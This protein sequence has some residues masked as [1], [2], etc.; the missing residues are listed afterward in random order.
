MASTG[1]G[2]PAPA[3]LDAKLEPGA[4]AGEYIVES[5]LGE[6]AFGTV[7]RAA[8]GVIGKPAAVKVLSL[9]HAVDPG[10]VARFIE[11]AR[12]VNRIGHPDIIDIFGFGKLP[13][14]RQFYVMELLHGETLADVLRKRAPM[15]PGEVCDLLQPVSAALDAAH[16]AGVAHRDVKPE[17]IFLHDEGGVLRPKLLDFGVAK[18]SGDEL[19][20]HATESGATVGTPSYMSP[21]QCVGKGVDHRADIYAFGV[22]AFEML[23]GRLPFEEESRFHLM[24]AHLSADVPDPQSL[25]PTLPTGVHAALQRIMAK[26]PE[27]RPAT[28]HDAWALLQ[29]ALCPGKA[30]AKEG[31]K[32]T[33]L[34]PHASSSSSRSWMAALAAVLVLGMGGAFLW[35]QL[36]GAAPLPRDVPPTDAV[37][38]VKGP[39]SSVVKSPP[40]LVTIELQGVPDEAVVQDAA[41]RV[42]RRGPGPVSVVASR[43]VTWS[44]KHNGAAH[45]VV[46]D[47]TS[48]Q[49]VV[50]PAD[51]FASAAPLVQPTM[52]TPKKTAAETKAPEKKASEKKAAAP[53]PSVKATKSDPTSRK[54]PPSGKKPPA[55]PPKTRGLNDLEPW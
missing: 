10:I 5:L 35:Q 17:N 6:G 23:T 4:E 42:L 14:G 2:R 31:T 28:V 52:T 9:R 51:A 3:V 46:V 27:D 53:S 40:T 8:H 50:V 45:D 13:D 18:L 32:A 38:G 54:A 30:V 12:A 24:A 49:T 55:S 21:E 11:E 33:V 25:V 29:S 1:S 48:A 37:D 43:Q 39:A 15:P 7:Y 22:L 19:G 44:V 36:S 47:A 16:G 41:G 20:E 34:V 26:E